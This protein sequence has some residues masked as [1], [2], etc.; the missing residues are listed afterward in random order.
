MKFGDKLIILRKKNGMSQEE[1]AERL[2]V[3]R[4]SVSKW[5]SNNTYPETDKIVQ[6]ANLF[7]CSMDDL[8]ND[9]I[10][11]VEGS[12]RKNKNNFNDILDSFLEFITRSVNM[13]SK[14]KFSEGFKCIIEMLVLALILWFLGYIICS[15]TGAIFASL[16]R[17][18]SH[19]LANNIGTITTSILN[20]FWFILSII[21]LIHTFKIKYL[22]KYTEEVEIKKEVKPSKSLEKTSSKVVKEVGEEPFAFLG[23]LSKIIIYFIKFITGCFVLSSICMLILLLIAIVTSTYL[24]PSNMLFT[25]TTLFLLSSIIITTQI[26]LLLIYFIINKKVNIKLNLIVF[27]ISLFMLGIGLGI[28]ILSLKNIKVEENPNLEATEV[29]LLYSDNLVISSYNRDITY[30]YEVDDTIEDNKI[31]VSKKIDSNISSIS[32]SHINIED[33]M[34][35]IHIYED[36]NHDY[37]NLI[38]EIKDGLKNNTIRNFTDSNELTIKGNTTTI[39]NLINNQKKLFLVKEEINDNKTIINIISDRVEFRGYYDD[40]IIFD[41]SSGE[42]IIEDEDYQCNKTI[43]NTMYGDKL[44]F[45]CSKRNDFDLDD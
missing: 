37:N 34:K 44:V 5:E 28:S 18:I 12:L 17:F 8:I 15:I 2:N 43:K 39:N 7:E 3:S 1:L 4:Q 31:I 16:F 21:V 23:I 19:Q 41:A 40:D 20:I 32:K 42:L 11:D 24:I 13:F 45:D 10:T 6:I 26:I 35:V 25:G 38:R 22:N 14:M 29:E 27:I 30:I 36:F 9:K 33:N